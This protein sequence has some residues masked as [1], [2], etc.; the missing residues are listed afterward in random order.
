LTTNRHPGSLVW[1]AK[2]IVL[3]FLSCANQGFWSS[4]SGTY[5]H[6][7]FG[8]LTFHLSNIPHQIHPKIWV[9]E[10]WVVG[11]LCSILGL[12][13][14]LFCGW[15]CAWGAQGWPGM[16]VDWSCDSVSLSDFLYRGVVPLPSCKAS[17]KQTLQ[18]W[19]N[20]GWAHPDFICLLSCPKGPEQDSPTAQ[21]GAG[22][23]R[24]NLELS[25]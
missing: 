25:K 24:I 9:L 8:A 11:L 4:L 12:F 5:E 2:V 23:N 22:L 14:G 16:V 19:Q 18:S 17:D 21:L 3:S 6:G 7:R 13:L 1:A 20:W 10:G 15:T